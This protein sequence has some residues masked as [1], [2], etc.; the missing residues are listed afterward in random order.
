MVVCNRDFRDLKVLKR[1]S[2][3]LIDEI[4]KSLL[5]FVNILFITMCK[6]ENL[7]LQDPAFLSIDN[8]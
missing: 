1:S 4:N 6:E 5:N 2:Y 3:W 8:L 7:N